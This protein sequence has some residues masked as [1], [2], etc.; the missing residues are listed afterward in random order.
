MPATDSIDPSSTEN[1]RVTVVDSIAV[2]TFDRPP[3]NALTR[4]AYAQIR[5]VFRSF[6]DRTDIRVAIFTATGERA[7]MAGADIKE[8][9][10]LSVEGQQSLSVSSRLDRGTVVRDSLWA[11]RDCVVPVILALNAPAIGAGVA[12]AAMADFIVAAEGVTLAATEINVGM[13]GATAHLARLV[14]PSRARELFYT[15]ASVGVDELFR[16]GTVSRVVP[17]AELMSTAMGIAAQIAAKSPLAIRL[18]KESFNRVEFLPLEDGYRLEQDYTNRLRQFSD[19]AEAQR[20]FV[21]KDEPE[22]KWQ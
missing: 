6:V 12:Y 10:R 17:R 1:V 15:A 16:R 20:A 11:V 7:F 21:E 4:D 5:D 2:V 22:W 18:A 8:Q 3:V 14:G 13:L 19:S 9:H